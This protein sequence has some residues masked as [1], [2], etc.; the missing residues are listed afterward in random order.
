MIL[1]GSPKE[2][3][4]NPDFENMVFDGEIHAKGWVQCYLLL[5]IGIRLYKNDNLKLL[6]ERRRT[7]GRE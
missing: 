7:N 2:F 6:L 1:R 5:I 3:R 4:I